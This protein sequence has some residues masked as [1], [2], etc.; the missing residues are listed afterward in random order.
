MIDAQ[1]SRREWAAPA[2]LL[3]L[4][5]APRLIHLGGFLTIDEPKWID[6][7]GQAMI[8]LLDGDL[9][10]TYWHFF[11]GMTVTWLEALIL[12][13][14]CW[15]DG[16]TAFRACVETQ[17]GDLAGVVGLLR[18]APVLINSLAVVAIYLLARK[19]LSGWVAFLGCALLALDPFFVAHSRIVNGDAGAAAFMAISL[20]SFIVYCEQGQR[21]RYLVTSGLCGGLAFLTKLPSPLL[22]PFIVL[23]ALAAWLREREQWKTWLKAVVV[24]GALAAFIFVALFPALWVAPLATFQQAYKDVFEMGHIGAGHDSFFLGQIDKDP[25]PLFY[26]YVIAFRLTPVTSLGILCCLPLLIS[27]WR[28]AGGTRTLRILAAYVVFLVVAAT[29]GPKKLDRYLMAVFPALDLLAAAGLWAVA[30][31]A[32][33]RWSQRVA[34]AGRGARLALVGALALLQ[35]QGLWETYPYYLNYY[36]PL[37]GGLPRAARELRLGWG[38]GL[39]QAAYYLNARPGAEQLRVASWYSDIFNPYFVG[40]RAPFSNNGKSL[41]SADYVVFYANQVQRQKPDAGIVAYFQRRG[42]EYTVRLGGVEYA[43]VYRAP[44]MQHEV[45]GEVEI[46]GRAWLLGYDLGGQLRAG[47]STPLTFYLRC[48][49]AAGPEQQISAALVGADNRA[50]GEWHNQAG[51]GVGCQEGEIVEWGGDLALPPDMPPGEYRLQVGL[52][53]AITGSA[54][55]QFALPE[56][57]GLLVQ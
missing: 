31:W 34:V 42:A 50:W 44:G 2:I 33:A 37:L 7:A 48:L 53:D 28:S 56:G 23:L 19:L 15:A 10:R 52:R 9:A 36:N 6:G 49:G 47:R 25:G 35:S 32:L 21:R 55:G 46:P 4:A 22:A 20:L 8:A 43:W 1:E 5:L 39:E 17:V 12:A 54:I 16:G 18:L 41:L 45:S 51:A 27:G 29:F 30:D 38:E 26:P 3:A 57:E 14:R 13:A 11:P 24:W 40:Q